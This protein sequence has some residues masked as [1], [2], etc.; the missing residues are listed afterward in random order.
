MAAVDYFLKIDGIEGESLDNAHKNEIDVL[1][2]SW[3]LSLPAVQGAAGGGAGAGKAQM[4]DFHF[5]AN[6]SKASPKLMLATATGQHIKEAVLTC[7]KAGGDR[8]VEFL[9]YTMSDCLISSYQIA[10][11]QS[12]VPADSA[13]LNF[14]KIEIEFRSTNPD[15]SIGAST[16][17]AFD[18]RTNKAV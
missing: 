10:G 12:E 1:S 15:G 6:T 16:K 13:S 2:W 14:V 9:K 8:Q 18:F 4:Q 17:A 3:G 7:R 5:T 11:H